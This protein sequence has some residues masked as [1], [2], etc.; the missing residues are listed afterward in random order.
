MVRASRCATCLIT[1]A[2]MIPFLF[3]YTFESLNK[4]TAAEPADM[5]VTQ[6]DLMSRSTTCT[7]WKRMPIIGMG[8]GSRPYESVQREGYNTLQAEGRSYSH[9]F[10]PAEF[11]DLVHSKIIT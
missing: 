3:Y 6:L 11:S 9:L 7:S 5:F 1:A 4:A 2:S 8:T 10:M